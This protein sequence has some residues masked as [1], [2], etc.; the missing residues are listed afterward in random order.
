[1]TS[2]R[3]N[4]ITRAAAHLRRR[5]SKSQLRRR[6][7]ETQRERCARHRGT[8]RCGKRSKVALLTA[9]PWR[10]SQ[11]PRTG[12]GPGKN[13]SKTGGVCEEPDSKTGDERN[14]SG[15]PR[16]SFGKTEADH[17]VP[18]GECCRKRVRTPREIHSQEDTRRRRRAVRE[19]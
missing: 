4:Q 15:N 3:E 8:R 13:Q 14:R 19:T 5:R 16:R 2:H 1:V 11:K 18:S 10:D 17:G 7:E 12:D 6:E 9:V